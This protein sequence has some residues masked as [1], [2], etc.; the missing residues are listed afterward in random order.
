MEE[1]DKRFLLKFKAAAFELG[2]SSHR[3]IESLKFRGNGYASD[4]DYRRLLEEL[5]SLRVTELAGD[6]PSEDY[7][8]RAWKVTDSERNSVIIVEHETG[9][10]I[11][12]VAGAVASV[13]SLVPLIVNL[14]NRL[15]DR[16]FP[17][18]WRM[19]PHRLERRILDEHNHL[20]DSPF[21]PLDVVVFQRLA[22]EYSELNQRVAHLEKVV[23]SLEKR[24]PSTGRTNRK[25]REDRRT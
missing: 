4:A 19:S 3:E 15:R 8:G 9:L 21:A 14:W 13:A 24:R 23:S 16:D 2:C 10:E 25:R 18:P 12:Y 5:K 20:I 7:L 1:R 17:S 22:K 11:L 6:K